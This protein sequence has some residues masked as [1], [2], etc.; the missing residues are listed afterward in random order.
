MQAYHKEEELLVIRNV[1]IR[2]HMRH[3]AKERFDYRLDFDEVYREISD[4]KPRQ[5]FINGR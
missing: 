1:E 3:Q 5:V 2:G 4:M